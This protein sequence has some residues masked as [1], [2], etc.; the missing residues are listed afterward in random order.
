MLLCL[1]FIDPVFCVKTKCEVL[2]LRSVFHVPYLS[3]D[4][5]DIIYQSYGRN[6]DP[7]RGRYSD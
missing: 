3:N 1:L 5:D 6:I 2:S 7:A 4:T